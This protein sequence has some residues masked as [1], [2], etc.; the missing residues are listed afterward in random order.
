M[1]CF[2]K[3]PS[4]FSLPPKNK[5]TLQSIGAFSN[6]DDKKGVTSGK[7]QTNEPQQS[8]DELTVQEKNKKLKQQF[9]RLQVKMYFTYFCF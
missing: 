6:N 4:E 2:K 9:V 1:E 8:L 3:P 5:D 7:A